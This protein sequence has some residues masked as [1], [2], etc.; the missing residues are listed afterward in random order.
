M[1]GIYLITCYANMSYYVGSSLRILARFDDHIRRLRKGDHPNKALQNTYR[2]YGE[3][4][5]GVCLLK[6]CAPDERLRLEQIFIDHFMAKHRC[7]NMAKT[8][9]AP[10]SGRTH[11][12]E[13]RAKISA[14]LAS[15]VCTEQTRK[16][17][18]DVHKG[19]H[20]SIE[21]RAK[22]SAAHKG[23]KM[24]PQTKN[25]LMKANKGR[26]CS[27]ETRRKIGEANSRRL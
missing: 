23:R 11:S 15:C 22:L 27:E 3:D 25:A 12:E 20:V 19:K 18:S 4:S 10:M 2:K 24:L 8:T 7:L 26:P 13:A 9:T 21:T 16:K 1:T 6:R 17:R 5:F 14:A